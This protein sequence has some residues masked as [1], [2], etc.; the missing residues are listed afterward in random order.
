MDNTANGS[1]TIWVVYDNPT[2]YPGRFVARKWLADTPTQELRLA[3]SLE[4][5]RQLLPDG[6]CCLP[7]SPVDDPK[8]VETWF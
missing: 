6:L 4:E 5:L 7:R 3:D 2:D 8:I 1:L